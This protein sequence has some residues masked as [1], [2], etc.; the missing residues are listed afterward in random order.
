M[1]IQQ[2]IQA[3]PTAATSPFA[4]A[5]YVVLLCAWVVVFWLRG[6]PVRKT[7]QILKTYKDDDARTE[8]LKNFLGL[9]PPDGLPK[10][11]IMDWVREQTRAKRQTYT[12]IGILAFLLAIVVVTVVAITNVNQG[13]PAQPNQTRLRIRGAGPDGVDCLRLPAGARVTVTPEGGPS[14]QASLTECEVVLDW[15]VGWRSGRSARL[16][17]EGAGSFERDKPDEVFRLGDARWEVAMRA[18]ATAPR[19]LVQVYDYPSG[20][21]LFDQFYLLVRNKIQV[22]VDS[23]KSRCEPQCTYLGDLRVERAGREQPASPNRTL[24]DWR[25]TNALLFLSGLFF[26]RDSVDFVSSQPFFGELARNAGELNRVP[27]ELRIDA[28]ELG[29]TTDSHSLALLYALAM[30]A[31]RVGRP[32]DII[33][34]LL[35]EAVSI[36]KGISGVPGVSTLKAQL[37]KALE[38]LGAPTPPGL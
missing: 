13:G 23:I 20:G 11:Q 18:G 3:L 35:G 36:E 37:D 15:A 14:Q 6:Q 16:T 4:L 34:A 21:V 7:E 31:E 27:L 9:D 10:A 26:R 29:R 17:I 33:L 24:A 8:A 19:L 2:F 25:S 22:L 12:L 1:D 32:K 5:A 38:R 28:S 30:D